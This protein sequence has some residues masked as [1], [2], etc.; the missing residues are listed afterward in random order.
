[1]WEEMGKRCRTLCPQIGSLTCSKLR[2]LLLSLISLVMKNSLKVKVITQIAKN[3]AHQSKLALD[4]S[5]L[6]GSQFPHL[7]PCACGF[8]DGGAPW[9]EFCRA[10]SFQTYSS[11]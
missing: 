1:M 7:L 3:S 6:S 4:E 10:N 5:L 8:R 9:A 11:L 2:C